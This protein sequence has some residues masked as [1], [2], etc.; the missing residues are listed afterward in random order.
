M[1]RKTKTSSHSVISL[2]IGILSILLPF[3]GL[4]LG[5]IGIVIARKAL[6]EIEK[7]G[8]IGG[9]LATSGLICS[10]VGFIIQLFGVL[11]IISFYSVSN[12][13]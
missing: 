8:Y 6:K 7:T 2:S 1:D 13:G 12:V 9:G 11:G 3:L 4:V 10:S 5:V